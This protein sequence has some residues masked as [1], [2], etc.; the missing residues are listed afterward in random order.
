MKKDTGIEIY[1]KNL[2]RYLQVEGGSTLSEIYR[3]EEFQ[4]QQ[5]S[6]K[7]DSG[8]SRATERVVSVIAWHKEPICALVNNKAEH[9]GFRVFSP[10]EIEYLDMWSS[11]GREV[12]VRSMCMLLYKAV[13]DLYSDFT[14]RIEHS[15]SRGLFCRLFDSEGESVEPGAAMT[16]TIKAEM[17]KLVERKLPFVRHEKLTKDVVEIFRGQKLRNKVRL[18]ETVP[19]LYT[20]Y[21]E[22][23]GLADSFYGPLAPSTDMLEVFDLQAWQDGMLLLGPDLS[24]PDMPQQ[25]LTQEKMFA[26][27][28]E[29][30]KFNRVIRVDSVGELNEAVLR[31][32]ASD[33]I[34]VAEAMHDKLIGRIS[35]EIVSRRRDGGGMIVM[36]AGPSSSGKTTTSKRLA[37]QLMTNL[38][39]PKLISLDDYFVNRTDTPLDEY[40]QYDYE[41]LYALDLE[42]LQSDLRALLRGETIN[43]PTYSFE[44]GQRVE[45]ERPLSLASDEVLIIEG[46]HGLNPELTANLPTE[47]IFKMYVSALTSLRIDNHNWISTSDNR[48]LRRLVRDYKYRG[49][50]PTE[51]IRRWPSVRRGEEKWIFPFQENADAT[52]NS[53][54]LFEIAVMK[55]YVEPLLSQVAHNEPEYTTAYRLQRFLHY[56]QR[57]PETEVPPTSLLREF[58]GGSSFRY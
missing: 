57:I 51:T 25:P 45:R 2:K 13:H 11:V 28:R 18:L 52:F 42:R 29:H 34:N 23:D 19:D 1:S 8:E 55:P 6:L 36:I 33:L 40:G 21:Y 56:F 15:I 17:K 30:L 38:M 14:L 46:I 44:L 16:G 24:N 12:Y 7:E 10:K 26:A 31:G 54:L 49:T 9:L 20:S 43:L 22:L 32:E 27:F 3:S 47:R 37:I 58:L 39:R 5:L 48:L 53:S 4:K 35:D 41:S 50:S